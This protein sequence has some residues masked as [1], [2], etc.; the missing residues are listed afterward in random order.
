MVQENVNFQQYW[1]DTLSEYITAIARSPHNTFAASSAAGE[2]VLWSENDI[3]PL[4]ESINSAINSLAFSSN[5]Q[6]LAAGGQDGNVKIWR[7]THNR[8]QQP[9]NK[10]QSEYLTTLENGSSWIDKLRWSPTQP[11]LAFGI[12]H[13][14][15]I[16]N[17]QTQELIATLPFEASS[18]LDIA[19]SPNGDYLAVAGN[20]GV[21]IWDAR[22]WNATPKAIKMPVPC[23]SVAWSK[24]NQYL[25]TTN[26]DLVLSVWKWGNPKPWVMRGFPGKIRN[27]TWSYLNVAD[28]PLLAV[29]SLEDIIIWQKQPD[30]KA[31]SAT[32]LNEHSLRIQ[33]IAFSRDR[34]LLAS[35]SDDGKLCLWENAQTLT[36]TLTGATNGF[37]CLAWNFQGDKI[38]AGGKNGEL[39]IWSNQNHQ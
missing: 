26:F 9:I 15:K 21:K 18:P 31:W 25:A 1:Q 8:S 38:A 37:S 3:L 24:N 20:K 22:N 16:W 14:L 2:V 27:L 4:Q 7:I 30:D 11:L 17:A 33:D 10:T 6:Y 39:I 28:A 5:G 29:T 35:A 19:W 32:V 34:L 36:Q 13:N 23:L 12:G